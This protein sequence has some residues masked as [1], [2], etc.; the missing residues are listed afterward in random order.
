MPALVRV[1][2]GLLPLPLQA[3][4]GTVLHAPGHLQ[5][6]E[7]APW[8]IISGLFKNIFKEKF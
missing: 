6:K 4:Q 8:W 1:E 2:Q 3:P 5:G 7:D